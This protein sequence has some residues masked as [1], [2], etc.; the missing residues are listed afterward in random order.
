M[1]TAGHFVLYRELIW[2]AIAGPIFAY[3]G[4]WLAKHWERRPWVWAILGFFFTTLAVLTL[5][6]LENYQ[7]HHHRHSND[8]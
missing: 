2:F 7:P 3:S 1:P 5:V 6:V 4:A 8:C